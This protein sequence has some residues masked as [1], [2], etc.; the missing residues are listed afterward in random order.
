MCGVPA[1]YTLLKVTAA[2]S[3]RLLRYDQ[4]VEEPTQSVVSFAAAALYA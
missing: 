4:A 1:L 2:R 3:A